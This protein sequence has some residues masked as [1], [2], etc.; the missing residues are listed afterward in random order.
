MIP[1]ENQKIL[2]SGRMINFG[3]FDER[4]LYLGY[5]LLQNISLVSE[6]S[7]NTENALF[8][9]F[10]SDKYYKNPEPSSPII[11]FPLP[12]VAESPSLHYN[13]HLLKS[14]IDIGWLH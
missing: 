8:Y 3:T 5:V 13:R 4:D 6:W 7:S 9:D 14:S 12:G 1:K 11:P 2:I 10:N